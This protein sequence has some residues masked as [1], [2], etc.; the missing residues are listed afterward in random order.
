[1]P[2]VSYFYG[3]AIYMYYREHLPPHF[4]A[5]YGE[6]EAL[7]GIETLAILEG[8]MPARALGLI[9]EWASL[10]QPDLRRAWQQALTHQLIDPIESLA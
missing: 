5:I 10:H 1:M 7:V 2:R 9:I 3:I 4:H 8:R 6:H